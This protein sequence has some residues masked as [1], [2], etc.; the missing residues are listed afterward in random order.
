MEIQADEVYYETPLTSALFHKASQKKIPLSGTFEVSPLCNFDCRMCY[1][2][3]SKQQIDA[4]PRKMLTLKQWKE[5]ADAAE[6][7]GMLYLLITGGEPFLWPDFWELYE[8]ITKKGFVVTINSNGSLIDEEVVARLRENP[9]FRINL[10]LYGVSD[11]TYERLCKV[12]NGF[13]K[14]DHAI[15]ALKKAGIRVKLNCSLTPYNVCDLEKMIQYAQEQSVIIETNT[16]MFPP[17]RKSPDQVGTNDRFSPEEAAKWQLRRYQ[18][19]YGQERYEAFLE[20]ICNGMTQPAGLMDSCYEH[21]DGSVRCR[22][23]KA[24]FWITWDGYLTPCGM[25]PIPKVDCVEAGFEQAW[26]Y[27]TKE[28]EKICLSG[29]CESCANQGICHSCAAMAIAETG[30]FGK[31]PRYLCEMMQAMKTIAQ[32]ERKKAKEVRELEQPVKNFSRK[33]E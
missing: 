27:I 22:A 2:R 32:I 17:I 3:Q 5:I 19:Q 20:G 18:L 11:E 31:I 29:V 25:M 12:K 24:A 4:H 16:Y 15:T 30:E 8:Y 10:T 23:G 21:S 6:K 33:V 1:V 26:N 7:K 9:P 28:T 13:S 14:V